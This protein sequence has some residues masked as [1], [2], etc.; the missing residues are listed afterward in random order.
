MLEYSIVTAIAIGVSQM[1]KGVGVK[2]KYIPIICL[3]LGTLLAMVMYGFT[4]GVL[5]NGLVASLTA[6]GLYSG[7]KATVK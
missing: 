5:L 2:T 6:M 7:T 1:I 3:V 4:K